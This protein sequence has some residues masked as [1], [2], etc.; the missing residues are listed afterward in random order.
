MFVI[1]HVRCAS[2]IAIIWDGLFN[3]FDVEIPEIRSYYAS[4][5]ISGCAVQ[6]LG[7]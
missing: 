4:S 6:L 1:V 3:Q 5:I 2:L 7:L